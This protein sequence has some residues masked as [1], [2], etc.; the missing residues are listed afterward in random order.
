MALNDSMY[1]EVSGTTSPVAIF[2]AQMNDDFLVN[3]SQSLFC[4]PA[5]ASKLGV[6]YVID[7]LTDCFSL[8]NDTDLSHF[9]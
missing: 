7:I 8:T 6:P 4:W 2:S 3:S 1:L 9:P 5:A